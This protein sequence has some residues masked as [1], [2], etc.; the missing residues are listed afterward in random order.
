MDNKRRRKGKAGR[1]EEKKRE[2]D[3]TAVEHAKRSLGPADARDTRVLRTVAH[4]SASASSRV[5]SIMM[6]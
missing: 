4:I 3:L 2:Q 6:H 1:Q 5:S